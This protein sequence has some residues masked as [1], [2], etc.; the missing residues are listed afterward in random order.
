MKTKFRRFG[1]SQSAASKNHFGHEDGG[2]INS[3]HP[4]VKPQ[5]V[6]QGILYSRYM[7]A[8][9]LCYRPELRMSSC[10]WRIRYV[11][12]K[13]G[14]TGVKRY[15]RLFVLI[16]IEVF[17]GITFVFI[18]CSPYVFNFYFF[19]SDKCTK[20]TVF[21]LK[22]CLERILDKIRAVTNVRPLTHGRAF[23]S[24]VPFYNS[25]HSWDPLF[26]YFQ[27][28][29]NPFLLTT[30]P[31]QPSPACIEAQSSHPALIHLTPLSCCKIFYG[32]QNHHTGELSS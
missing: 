17:S 11:Q 26:S 1:F 9:E 22:K 19:E 10:H 8:P 21:R 25:L 16:V 13:S 31:Q 32:L 6:L 28:V 30:S 3:L 7:G 23:Q 29:T 20:A 12:V 24:S 5:Q 2:S 14:I 15:V 18:Q 4:T 27:Q